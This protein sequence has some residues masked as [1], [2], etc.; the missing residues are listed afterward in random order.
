MILEEN[1]RSQDWCQE[2]CVSLG[3]LCIPV[4]VYYSTANPEW[5]STQMAL[6][7]AGVEWA[8]YFTPLCLCSVCLRNLLMEDYQP[9]SLLPPVI[10][11]KHKLG[12]RLLKNLQGFPNAYDK[13][14]VHDWVPEYSYI[15]HSI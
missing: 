10:P 14:S 5:L 3:K 8:F 2:L 11:P 9:F 12:Y 4:L 13:Q 7:E 6:A 15:L 1:S